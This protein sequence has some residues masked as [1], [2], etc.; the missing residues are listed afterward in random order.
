MGMDVIWIGAI[1][2]LWTAMVWLV[3]AFQKLAPSQGV[4]P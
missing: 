4:R 1:A 2:L 3:L